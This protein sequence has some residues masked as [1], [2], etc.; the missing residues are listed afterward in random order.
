MNS[1]ALISTLTSTTI[2]WPFNYT[3]WSSNFTDAE[4][5]QIIISVT[6]STTGAGT[7]WTNF[8][9]D[10]ATGMQSFSGTPP[11]DNTYAGTYTFTV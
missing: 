9:Q 10:A 1:P 6:K 3:F 7:A 11:L 2:P 4:G 5:D 8:A